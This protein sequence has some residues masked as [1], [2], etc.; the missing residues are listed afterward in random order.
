[1]T[2]RILVRGGG[3]LASGVVLRLARAGWQVF[4]LELPQPLAVRRSVS[5]SQAVYDGQITVEGV[6]ARLADTI[7]VAEELVGYGLVAVMVDPEME[8][9][10][11]L[12]PDVMVDARMLK[13][14][15]DATRWSKLDIGLGPGFK[16]GENTDAA[17]ETKRG[18][19]LGR[20]YWSGGP[21]EDTGL[22]DSVGTYRSERVIRAPE[23]GKVELM[24]KIGDQVDAGTPIIA[25]NGHSLYASFSGVLRGLIQDGLMVPAGLKIGDL[26][27]RNEPD[28]CYRVSD[29]ALAVGGGVL[30][31]I[32]TKAELRRKMWD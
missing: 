14:F 3:D 23:A 1:M 28:L 27:P 21:A 25:I 8:T 2:L 16:A 11:L 4:I 20:V 13:V 22:P 9:I 15:V 30:E 10:K 26:D 6:S 24:A 18:P 32:L 19:D 5:F 29:K 12:A 7:T 17:I 31:A